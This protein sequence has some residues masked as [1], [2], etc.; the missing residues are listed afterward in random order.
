M[1]VG[2]ELSGSDR[3]LSV[4]L[5]AAEEVS[6][7]P[8]IGGGMPSADFEHCASGKLDANDAMIDDWGTTHFDNRND[9]DTVCVNAV[10]Q[11]SV[12]KLGDRTL[13]LRG[14]D[15]RIGSGADRAHLLT[16]LPGAIL[17]MN[18]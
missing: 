15:R 4:E 11:I 12:S 10:N 14:C 8:A 3:V 16:V 13:S 9:D 6:E 17:T 5:P 1:D 2:Y 7:R 18:G